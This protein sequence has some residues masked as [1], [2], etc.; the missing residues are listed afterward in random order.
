MNTHTHPARLHCICST[1]T[2]AEVLICDVMISE[3]QVSGKQS[4]LEEVVKVGPV[5]GCVSPMSLEETR[6]LILCVGHMKTA[7]RGY[8]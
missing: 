4:G 6:A 2:R 7:R 5:M 8:L 1:E 3:G